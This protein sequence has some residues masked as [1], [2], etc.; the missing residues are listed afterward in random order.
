MEEEVHPTQKPITNHKASDAVTAVSRESRVKEAVDVLQVLDRQGLKADS[1][2]YA[3]L[4]KICTDMK[5]LKEGK[6]VHT[7]MQKSGVNL[8]VILGTKLVSMYIKCGSLEDARDVFDKMPKRNTF[9]FSAMIGVYARHGQ[10]KEALNLYR[11]MQAEGV[12]PD[13]AIFVSILKM[14]SELLDT[15]LEQ[16]REIHD[17]VVRSGFESDLLVGNALIDMYGK[18]GDMENA[19]QVFDKMFKRDVVSWTVIIAG[20]VEM[21]CADET[22]ELFR[23]MQKEGVKPNSITVTSVLPMCANLAALRWGKEIQGYII[24]G[25]FEENVFVGSALVD[26]YGKCGHLENARRVFDKMPERDV[27]SWNAM[28]ASYA[29]RGYHEEALELFHQMQVEGIQPNVISWNALIGGYAQNGNGNYALKLF[30]QMQQVGLKPNSITVAS[31]LPACAQLAALQQGKEIH[32]YVFRRGF[33]SDVVVASA[34]VA[35][36][37][38]CGSI[39]DA[40]QV[41]KKMSRRDTIAWNTMIVALAMHG[42]GEDALALFYEMQD[43]GLKPNHVTFAGILSAC[44]HGGLVNEGWQFFHSMYRYYHIKPDADHY[45]CMVDL[46]SRAGCLDEAYDF[47]KKMPMKP[48][49]SAWGALLAACR[50]HGNVE[51]GK[52]AAERLFD[53]EPFNPSNYVLLSN[54]YAAAGRWDEV[55]NVRKT[56]KEKGLSKTPGC[57]WIEVENKVHTFIVG[58]RS[59]PQTERIYGMLDNLTGQMKE[60]G[61]MPNTDFVLHDLEGGEK[62]NFLC[63]HSEKLAI[64]FGLLNTFP[65]KPIRV[66]KNLRVCGDCHTAI[67]FISKIVRR[68]LIVRDASR[69]HHFKNG[70]CSCG[71]YW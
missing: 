60:A 44:S 10:G 21:G 59:H 1:N 61:Y 22:F 26:M 33:E 69:F 15:A 20:Y 42:H 24:R 65:G 12:Q 41:F 35:M 48:S 11:R 28:V 63:G 23:R 71:D 43:A 3:S 4:L 62:E 39:E 32:D 46:L 25:E 57:S 36:Y 31:I 52:C 13:K 2:T 55:S 6:Q 51:L 58:D 9:L 40:R 7:H 64:A 70:S 5:A 47:I 53:L 17:D 29:Q 18:C 45:A 8:P 66:I 34:V 67:K 27:V 68:E 49:A 30:R 16:T 37:A 54:I 14:C 19:R 56:M 50:I 38:K